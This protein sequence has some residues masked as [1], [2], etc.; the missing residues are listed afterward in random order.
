[1][2]YT[3]IPASWAAFL[4]YNQEGQVHLSAKK[5]KREKKMDKKPSALH[6]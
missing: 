3:G 5:L 1:M 6:L 4:I 2:M